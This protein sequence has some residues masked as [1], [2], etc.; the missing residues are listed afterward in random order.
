MHVLREAAESS[1]LLVLGG[2]RLTGL[3]EVFRGGGKGAALA[4]HLPCPLAL[5]PEDPGDRAVDA[6]VVV[7]VDGSDASRAAVEL[8]FA[9]A[10]AAGC[11]LAAVQVRKPRDA[12]SPGR[13]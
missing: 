8:A 10:A 4:G 7:G 6:P 2:R 13:R 12:A 9:E 1:D 3:D 11:S 5:V